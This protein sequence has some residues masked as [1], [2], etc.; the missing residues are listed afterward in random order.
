MTPEEA[1]DAL[2][3]I[4]HNQEM[5]ASDIEAD[6]EDADDIL[7]KLLSYLGYDEIVNLYMEVDK[8]YG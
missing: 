6:H 2:A 7:C 8:W 1:R 5:D 3:D 4:I